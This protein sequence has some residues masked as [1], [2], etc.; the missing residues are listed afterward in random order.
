VNRQVDLLHDVPALT[1]RRLFR[2][3]DYTCLY[4]GEQFWEFDLTRDHVIPVSRGGADS[5]DNV[6]TAC[7]ACN[8]RKADRSLDECEAIGIRLLAVPFVPNRAEGLILANREILADRWTFC[9]A[10]RVSYLILMRTMTDAERP[11]PRAAAPLRAAAWTVIH[12]NRYPT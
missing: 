8:Q 7:R 10:L 4:C 2:R 5:W 6:V 12:T 9:A 3:D 1:N 11:Q